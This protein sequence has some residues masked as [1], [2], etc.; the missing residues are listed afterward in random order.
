[1]CIMADVR[2]ILALFNH[3]HRRAITSFCRKVPVLFLFQRKSCWPNIGSV[4]FLYVFVRLFLARYSGGKKTAFL[5]FYIFFFFLF[6][7]PSQKRTSFHQ[8]NIDGLRFLLPLPKSSIGCHFRRLKMCFSF[9]DTFS[10]GPSSETF[11]KESFV[12]EEIK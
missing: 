4:V 2:K 12:F 9:N 3:H 5:D 11:K 10:E 8:G 7:L 1:M 6:S